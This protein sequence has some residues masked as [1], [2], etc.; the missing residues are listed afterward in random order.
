MFFLH[1][2]QKGDQI[3]LSLEVI[4]PRLRFVYVPEHISCD[5][6]Q[7]HGLRHLD[8]LPPVR[9]GYPR[10]VQFPRDDLDGLAIE[11][12]VIPFYPE[13]VGRGLRARG[14][15]R[16]KHSRRQQR[17]GKETTP[18]TIHKSSLVPGLPATCKL[19]VLVSPGTTVHFHLDNA[20]YGAGRCAFG[21]N[22]IDLP[23]HLNESIRLLC[24]QGW[25]DQLNA[26]LRARA[27]CPERQRDVAEAGGRG[28]LI[29]CLTIERHADG[30]PSQPEEG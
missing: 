5:R 12:K 20:Q 19:V 21:L 10:I 11:H 16:D 8:A 1:Q 9:P 18:L 30:I 23:I 17:A 2:L 22:L 28:A 13:A 6:I 25:S 26:K 29:Y 15:A 3:V 4:L 24:V 7:A 14:R 27:L